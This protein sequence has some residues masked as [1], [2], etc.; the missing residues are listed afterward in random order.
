M[1]TPVSPNISH[2]LKVRL[3]EKKFLNAH[4]V[5]ISVSVSGPDHITLFI[6]PRQSFKMDKWSFQEG[7]VWPQNTY[8]LFLAYAKHVGPWEFWFILSVSLNY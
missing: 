4:T 3:M 2:P 6:T 7:P 8:F 1:E 5:N